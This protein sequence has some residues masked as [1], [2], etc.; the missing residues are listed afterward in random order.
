MDPLVK[1]LLRELKEFREE[2]RGQM[3]QIE[4]WCAVHEA[5]HTAR[6]EHEDAEK[7]RSTARTKLAFTIGGIVFTALNTLLPLVFK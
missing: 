5:E 3:G 4:K 6:Q 7:A 2:V 1:E